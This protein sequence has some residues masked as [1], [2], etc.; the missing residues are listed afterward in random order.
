MSENTF[1]SF[2]C[3]KEMAAR[4]DQACRASKRTKSNQIRFWIGRALDA[5]PT[6]NRPAPVTAQNQPTS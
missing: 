4:I 3:P 6:E 5:E 1:I 2:Q